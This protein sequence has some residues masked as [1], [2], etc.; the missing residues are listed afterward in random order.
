MAIDNPIDHPR[1]LSVMP[2]YQCTAACTS[3]GTLSSPNVTTKLSTTQVLKSIDQARGAGV[4]VVVFTGGE[5]TLEMETLLSG[6][7][8]ASAAGLRT[9]LVTNAHWS[10]TDLQAV[11]ILDEFMAAGLNEINFSTGDQHARFVPV[12]DVLRAV[13]HSLAVGLTPA[14]MIETTARAK[15]TRALLENDA[16]HS[17][18]MHI[19]PGRVVKFNESPWMP[20]KPHRRETYAEGT[21]I[22]SGNID[23]AS[24][25][26]SVLST[27]TV[28][29]DGSLGACC[30][31]G[32]RLIPELQV[33]HVDEVPI[34]AAFATAEQDLLKRWIRLEGPERILQWAAQKDQSIE[35]EGMYAHRCQACLR[36]YKDPAV[37]QII[38]QNYAEKVP[39]ILFG[40]YLLYQFRHGDPSN[41]IP[42]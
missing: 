5:A 33:G 8:A 10:T 21:A 31:L 3:C 39:D 25:C 12:H 29:A 30:G 1:T 40:E 16:Y 24:G 28:Q 11:H 13:R 35:W 42:G 14:V 22:D 15:V 6:L 41:E 19:Y 37:R 4:G 36:M 23:R 32:M 26:D 34:D 38:E 9:R 27:L 17:E 18:T 7:S 20:L 2:T